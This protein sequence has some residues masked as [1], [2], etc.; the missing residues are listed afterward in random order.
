MNLPDGEVS[1]YEVMEWAQEQ[2]QFL[3]PT[4]SLVLWYLCVNAWRKEH[5]REGREPG[6]VMSGKASIRRIQMGT[7]LSERSVRYALDALQDNGY[8]Y[9]EHR[10]GRRFS[11]IVV[12]WSGGADDR[13]AEFRAGVRDL[14]EAMKRTTRPVKKK[15]K[16]AREGNVIHLNP[17]N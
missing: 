6:E 14:P 16:V 15:G 1:L 12:F 7:G 4:Q 2:A 8:I 3:T 11:G 13:R 9:C 5:N 17:G 10:N